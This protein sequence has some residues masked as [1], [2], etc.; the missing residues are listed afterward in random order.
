MYVTRIELRNTGPIEHAR[1]ECRFNDDGSPKPI[2]LVG[3]NGSGKSVATAHLVSALLEAQGTV[4]EDSDVESGKVY[5]LRSASYVRTGAKYST[6]EIEFSGNF[7]VSELQLTV[8]KKEYE[9]ALPKYGKWDNVEP[10]ATSH[11][12]SNFN[13]GITSLRDEMNSSTHL[14]FPPNRFEE[15]AWLNDLN[16]RN[17][18][19]YPS[20]NYFLNHSNRPIIS[21]APMRDLQ[22]WLLDLI[23]DSYAIER[24]SDIEFALDE[25]G[26]P[27]FPRIVETRY[28]PATSILDPIASFLQTLFQRQGTLTWHV[29]SRNRRHIGIRIGEEEVARNLFQLSSGQTVLLDLFLT[30]IKDFDL[31]D[32][33]LREL[34]DITGTVVVDEIDLHLHTDLQH[35]LLPDLIKL[36][37]KVQFIATTHSPLF[38]I[39]MDKVFTPEGYQLIELPDGCEIEAERFSEFEA[40]YKHMRATERFQAENFEQILIVQKPILFVEDKYDA[41]YKIAYLKIKGIEIG[42]KNFADL[43]SDHSPFE[44]RRGEGAG[45]VA[46]FLGMNNTDGYDDKKVIGLFDFDREG[47]ERFYHLKRKNN[48]D[49]RIEGDPTTG[50][51]KRR[52]QHDCFIALLLPIPERHLEFISSVEN[53]KF[54]SYVEVENLL[55]DR[56]LTENDLVDEEQITGSISY[57]K[58]KSGAKASL[59]RLL[60]AADPEIF[61]DFKPL[62]SKIDSLFGL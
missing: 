8:A 44:I 46:G 59:D 55:P 20:L 33:Q 41:I 5:K 45:S 22:N 42:S 15:P 27:I 9:G 32:A 26:L 48:W 40:A 6:A 61:E 17:K 34:G 47:T 49:E 53:G 37:P 3:Q 14:F 7:T 16:L 38:V 30:I 39:G 18:V 43:F 35:D 36:F 24:K 21:Y 52:N 12:S 29:G 2:V 4:F 56:F 57:K 50:L 25:T 51:F 11:Y 23:Y 31:G 60:V 19:N 10:T 13:A 1:I 54:G 62:F 28:G 58:V